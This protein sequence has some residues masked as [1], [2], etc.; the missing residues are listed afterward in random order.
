MLAK[1]DAYLDEA[2]KQLDVISQDK[3]KR[4]EYT[5]RQKAIND[6]NTFMAENYDRGLEEG[7]AEGR[8]EGKAEREAEIIASLKAYGMTDEQIREAIKGKREDVRGKNIKM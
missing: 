7:R 2:Y 5:S 8:A 6:Y 3:L 4:I 1:R